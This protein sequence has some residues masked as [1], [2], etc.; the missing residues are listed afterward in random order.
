MPVGVTDGDVLGRGVVALVHGNDPLGREPVDGGDPGCVDE[1]AVGEREEVESVV[2][3][4]EVGCAFERRGD[5]ETLGNFWLDARIVR[6]TAGRSGMQ[7]GGRE[8]VG[9]SEQRDVVADSNE[10]VGQ[11]GAEHCCLPSAGRARWRLT[12]SAQ[13]RR[14]LGLLDFHHPQSGAGYARWSGCRSDCNSGFWD[15]LSHLAAELIEG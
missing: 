7:G 1:L 15:H 12:G 14:S 8:R 9:R 6:P 4:V 3:D 10:P 5:V 2:D 11:Q 13:A